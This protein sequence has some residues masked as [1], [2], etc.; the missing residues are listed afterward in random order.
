MQNKNPLIEKAMHLITSF[1][2]RFNKVFDRIVFTRVGSIVISLL[3][4][5]V[6]CIVTDYEDLRI[7]LFNDT[8]TVVNLGEVSIETQID[9]S[10][11]QV[12]GVPSNVEV[13]LS[14]EAADVQIYRQQH[15]NLKIDLD[16]RQY[17]AGTYTLDLELEDLPANIS[18]SITPASVNCTITEKEVR[19]YSISPELLVGQGQTA[20]DFD[21]PTLDV[22]SVK[23]T[24]TQD[25]LNSI[26]FVRA[27]VDVS[28]FTNGESTQIQANIVAYDGDG[29]RLQ[30]EIEPK[31]VNATVKR[32]Q[33]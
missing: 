13:T 29:N 14:G 31:T 20:S 12:T 5:L 16:L 8:T 7:E 15:A 9:E 22:N 19:S 10:K 33:E 24:A 26:R 30:V 6:I 21:T 11:Y 3:A 27:I 32:N 25:V 17:P 2:H 28:S 4:S 18:A 23:I 1:F